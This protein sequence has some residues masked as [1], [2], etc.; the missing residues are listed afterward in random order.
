MILAPRSFLR[1]FVTYHC[2][3][4][5]IAK[6]EA[7]AGGA[8]QALVQAID[9]FAKRPV[10]AGAC[11]KVTKSLCFGN[12]LLLRSHVVLALPFLHTL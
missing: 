4:A 3:H 1:P 12:G 6:R 2:H 9:T 8:L 5:G 10:A 7:F 11:L